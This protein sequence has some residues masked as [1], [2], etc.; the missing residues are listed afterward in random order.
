MGALVN[1][2]EIATTLTPNLVVS[3]EG[4]ESPIKQAI[5]EYLKPTF[6]VS[7]SLLGDY[8]YAPYGTTEGS[9]I[10]PLMLV[11]FVWLLLGIGKRL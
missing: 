11:G 9:W 10:I 4:E 5:I 3:M 7:S 1:E 8:T 6:K 2:I